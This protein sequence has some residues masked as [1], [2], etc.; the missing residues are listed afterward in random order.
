[1]DV[2]VV[3]LINN[4]KNFLRGSGAGARAPARS[5]RIR[6]GQVFVCSNC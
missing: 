2:L 6:L 1:M 5:L 4:F 3:N